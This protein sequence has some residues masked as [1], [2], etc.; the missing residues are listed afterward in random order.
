VNGQSETRTIPSRW[1][2]ALILTIQAIVSLA[3]LR[4]TAFQDEALYLYGGRQIVGH[5]LGGPAPLDH[6]ASYFSGYPYIYPVIGGFLDRIGGLS[7]ARNFSLLCMLGVTT[8]VYFVAD[9]LLRRAAALFGTVI[10]A[11]T[12]VVLFVGRLATFDALCLFFIAL[13][14]SLAVYGG[15]RIRPWATLA[16]GPV[17][18]LAFLTK[19]AG[20]LFIP[21]V[22]ALLGAV[23]LVEGGRGRALSRVVL[24]SLSLAVSGLVTYLVMDR[25]ALHAI[26]GSTTN[27]SVGLPAP[28]L[29]LFTHVLQMAGPVYFMAFLGLLLLWRGRQLRLL[30]LVLFASSLLTPAYHIYNAEPVSLDK[31]IA[32]GLF[33]AAPLAG[34][35]LAWLCGYV[36]RPASVTQ[37]PQWVAGAAVLIV[38][39]T[40][41]Q[42]Q[43]RTLYAGWGNTS[44]LNYALHTQLRAGSGRVLAE[45]IEVARYDARDVSQEW[46]WNSFYYPYYI[47]AAHNYVFGQPALA[48]AV[49][50][51][52]YDLIELSFNYF[53]QEA[54]FLAGQMAASRNYDL[55]A[56]IPFH[57]SYG[58]GH[59]FMWRSALEPGQG[60]FTNVAQVETPTW[61]K[62]CTVAVCQP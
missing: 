60:S 1:P 31:H 61:F 18:V 38:L 30:A 12:G 24:A 37:R 41:G 62:K 29:Q 35:A 16:I 54:Y 56:V 40:L 27:R 20:L 39:I 23:S 36:P 34:Y 28:R 14:A 4:N 59:F 13:G 26:S 48:Q 51:Q 15:G 42:Q 11:F 32:Y 43:A 45:D 21:P 52:F 49:K 2:V 47:D 19:Y 3:T 25:T 8:M 46:Q 44:G 22:L 58:R 55:I 57:N 33:F 17:L 50:G 5:W 10:Y 7:L 6:Y 9:R 53:P